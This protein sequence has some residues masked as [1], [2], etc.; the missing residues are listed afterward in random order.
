MFDELLKSYNEMR[1]PAQQMHLAG[2][3]VTSVALHGHIN[4]QHPSV[5]YMNVTII[6]PLVL[7]TGLCSATGHVLLAPDRQ[8][9]LTIQ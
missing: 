2:V 8:T 3:K 6:K 9:S 4:P 7:E 5:L 1:F